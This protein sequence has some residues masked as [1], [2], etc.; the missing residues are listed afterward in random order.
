MLYSIEEIR[1]IALIKDCLLISDQY[2][3]YSSNLS[4]CC[5]KC[6]HIWKSSFKNFL[7]KRNPCQACGNNSTQLKLF[8]IVQKIYPD[9]ALNFRG[10][11]WLKT[12]NGTQE[13]DIFVPSAKLAIEYDGEQ[14]FMPVRFGG[15]SKERARENFNKTKK[16]DQRKNKCIKQHSADIKSF[17]R[18]N[19]K[20][21]I[22]KEYVVTKIIK[23][24]ICL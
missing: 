16:L 24:I 11:S 5:Q 20:E 1:G 6:G 13:I 12:K 9:A 2:K 14:H 10:F 3:N 23:H 22:N 17:I 15:I 21:P 18:F 7:Q 8:E 4:F 19:F